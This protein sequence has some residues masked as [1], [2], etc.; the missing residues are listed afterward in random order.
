MVES[1]IV[2]IESAVKKDERQSR[3]LQ[4]TSRML[5]KDRMVEYVAIT[6]GPMYEHAV[7][8]EDCTTECVAI[9]KIAGQSVLESK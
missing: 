8:E 1:F 3:F 2:G 7:I 6:G 5:H 4:M 9:K